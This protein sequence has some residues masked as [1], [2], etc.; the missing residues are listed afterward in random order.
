M[1]A[2]TSA[3]AITRDRLRAGRISL[4]AGVAILGGKLAATFVTGSTA[5]LSDALESVVNVVASAL[6][7]FSLLVASRPADR[8][9]P[10]GHGKVEF[11]SAGIEGALVF[12]A[13]LLIA[14]EA[15]R[16]LAT[17]VHL[18]RLDL[19]LGLLVVF[20]AGNAALGLFLVRV[21]RRTRSAALEADGRH[22]LVDVWTTAGVLLGLVAVKITGRP[23]IDPLVALAVAANILREGLRLVRDAVRGL[24]DAADED[25]LTA[26]ADALEAA[27]EPDWIDVHGLR[28][29]R[30]GADLHVD[31]HMQVPRYLSAERLHGIHQQVEEA[32][33]GQ[34]GSDGDVVVHFDPCRAHMCPR[35]EVP[36]CPVRESVFVARRPITRD[37]AR[38][39]DPDVDHGPGLAHPLEERAT[40]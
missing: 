20:S 14:V 36:E 9:H 27:R 17:G 37:S 2:E 23:V 11:F 31:F 25:E 5:V 7:L 24:M 10:Y 30:A 15:G 12:A 16:D 3:D 19:G 34:L 21:G 33:S 29:W 4:V 18:R 22:V 35:C 32:L 6:L 26:V 28:A 40:G 38:R 13:A 8:D 39:M 1:A